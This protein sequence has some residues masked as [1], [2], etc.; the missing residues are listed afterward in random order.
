MGGQ[1]LLLIGLMVLTACSQPV[2]V[3][4]HRSIQKYFNSKPQIFL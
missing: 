1:L 4:T 2:C 3:S